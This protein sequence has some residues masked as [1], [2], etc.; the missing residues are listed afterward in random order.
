MIK[1]K[2][3]RKSMFLII[4]SHISWAQQP[5]IILSSIFVFLPFVPNRENSDMILII[6]SNIS[7]NDENQ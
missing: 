5:N 2:K 6:R 3:G 7:S 4:T 1:R